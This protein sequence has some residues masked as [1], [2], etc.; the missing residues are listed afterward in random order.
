M[1][2]DLEASIP[3]AVCVRPVDVIA[4]WIGE[5]VSTVANLKAIKLVR[6]KVLIC[7]IDSE[8]PEA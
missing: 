4:V 1:N 8:R 3:T 7:T 2:K 6:N 5:I